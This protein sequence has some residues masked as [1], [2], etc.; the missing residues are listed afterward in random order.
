[1]AKQLVQLEDQLVA[2]SGISEKVRARVL[3]ALPVAKRPTRRWRT[4]VL[5]GSGVAAVAAAITLWVA[6]PFEVH[7]GFVV[8]A[9]PHP[10]A[11]GEWLSAS[12]TKSLPLNFWDGSQVVLAPR[13]QARVTEVDSDGARVVLESGKVTVHV[14]HQRTTRW[15]LRA[16]PFEVAVR[17]TR[18]VTDWSPERSELMVALTEGH[19][20]VTGPAWS[21]GQSVKAGET[22]RVR[23]AGEAWQVLPRGGAARAADEFEESEPL[24]P[25]DL[26]ELSESAEVSTVHGDHRP[27]AKQPEVSVISWQDLVKSGD[28]AGA[29]TRAKE[30]GIP[31]ILATSS[32]D[33]L[34]GLAQAAR[35]AGDPE[36][37]RRVL[38]AVRER[39]PGSAAYGVATYDLGRLAFDASG[40]YLEAAHWFR[41]YLRDYPAGG[42]AREASGRL[43]EALERGGDRLGA[44]QAARDYL[45]QFPNGP[46][47]ALARRVAAP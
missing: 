46:H 36:L 2:E 47:A 37:S 26:E 14:R 38:R 9:S 10:G 31:R 4:P 13:A 27:L 19:V 41:E 22:L 33:Q 28:Y 24:E 39:G 42:L 21:E 7:P 6:R 20:V 40:R 17:G 32:S 45:R 8:K 25:K 29:V 43:V 30:S 3:A 15:Q 35:F 44:A 16:G 23:K 1:V 5:V 18:F 12:S 11:V 34:L